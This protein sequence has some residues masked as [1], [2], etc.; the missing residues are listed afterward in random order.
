MKGNTVGFIS[1]LVFFPLRLMRWLVFWMIAVLLITVIFS[2][3]ADALNERQRGA[4]SQNCSTIQKS[5]S[6]LQKADSRTRSYLGTTY[7]T[8]VN[9]FII[10]LN[11]RLVK[12]NRPVL[13][14]IQANFTNEQVNFRTQYTDYMR[15]LEVLI[16]T[17]C[18]SQPDD[19]YQKLLEVRARRE[20][21]RQTT[22]RLSNLVEQQYA[23]VLDLRSQL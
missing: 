10:P 12:N 7:E 23:A 19:F 17:D 20:E 9:R 21:L 1:K 14:N 22:V 5:L 8:I 16:A 2:T 11:L 13:S 15:E 18:K 4:I 6:Q 3:P